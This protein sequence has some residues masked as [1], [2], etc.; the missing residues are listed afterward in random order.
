MQINTQDAENK[1]LI[2]Y[3]LDKMDLPL[4]TSQIADFFRSQAMMGQF[5]PEMALADMVEN[6]Y[7]ETER[8]DNV[9]R[10]SITCEGLQSLEY[11]EK[12]IPHHQRDLIKAYI[13]ENRNIIVKRDF[14]TTANFFANASN[15]EFTVKCGTYEDQRV[16]MEI[17]I[18]VDTTDQAR[19][20]QN[21]WK[22]HAKVLYGDILRTLA[23]PVEVEADGQP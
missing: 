1:L 10:Y 5:A 13:L 11:F 3:F 9:T 14:E 22:R 4:S 16:L 12:H 20:I 15:D 17:T 23:R 2:L 19:T 6:G 8:D 18:T 7:L 21:N